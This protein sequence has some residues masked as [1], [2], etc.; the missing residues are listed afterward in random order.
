MRSLVVGD[1][2]WGVDV[3]RVDVKRV[4]RCVMTI[5]RATVVVGTRGRVTTLASFSSW[6]S[7]CGRCV[8]G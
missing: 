6:M 7:A 2:E 4:A 1:W 3:K 8:W 5:L